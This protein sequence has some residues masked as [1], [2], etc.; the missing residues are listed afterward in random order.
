MLVH[1]EKSRMEVLSQ[2]IKDNLK[3]PCYFPANFERQVIQTDKVKTFE[4]GVTQ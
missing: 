3:L 4:V 2:V 1:G